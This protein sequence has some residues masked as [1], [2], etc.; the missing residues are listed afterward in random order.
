MWP[1]EV[2]LVLNVSLKTP[3]LWD[4]FLKNQTDTLFNK[5]PIKEKRLKPTERNTSENIWRICLCTNILK[6]LFIF[7]LTYEM[8]CSQKIE[9]FIG[10][11]RFFHFENIVF[12]G[13]C[14]NDYESNEIGLL[15]ITLVIRTIKIANNLLSINSCRLIEWQ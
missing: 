8:I 4:C 15:I 13:L 11:W 3:T 1:F 5:K 7:T 6:L 10:P 14:S 2:L 12:W 9:V